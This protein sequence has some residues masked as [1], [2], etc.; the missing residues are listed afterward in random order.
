MLGPL[1]DRGNSRTHSCAAITAIATTAWELSLKMHTSHLSFK[2]FFP[3]TT[4]KFNA[5]TM[6]A[7]NSTE[8][9]FK[10][11]FN[12]TRLRL[13]VTPLVTLRDDRGRAIL[14]KNIRMAGVILLN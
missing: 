3:E 11:Q 5:H 12:Q 9:P 10:L 2:I 6:I 7:T 13:V 4:S 1:L 8:D 14:V